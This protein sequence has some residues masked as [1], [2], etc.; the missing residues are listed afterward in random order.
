MIS[1]CFIQFERKSYEEFVMNAKNLLFANILKVLESDN[2]NG[3]N[4]FKSFS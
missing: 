2:I 3:I 4:L 1:E